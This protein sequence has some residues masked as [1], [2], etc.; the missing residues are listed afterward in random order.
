MAKIKTIISLL[1]NVINNR[2]DAESALNKW[3]DIDSEEDPLIAASWHDLSHFAAD[4][5]IR[6]KDDKYAELQTEMLQK[7]VDSITRKY[8]QRCADGKTGR[9]RAKKTPG[10]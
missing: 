4:W 2:E 6:E 9:S 5:D 1:E 10:T 3:P 8:E 7:R